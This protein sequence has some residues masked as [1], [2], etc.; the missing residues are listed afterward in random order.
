LAISIN[1]IRLWAAWLLL[2]LSDALARIVRRMV[3]G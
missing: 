3:P 1:V 2:R